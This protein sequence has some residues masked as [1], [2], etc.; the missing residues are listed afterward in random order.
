[1]VH[2]VAG[3]RHDAAAARAAEAVAALLRPGAAR[4]AGR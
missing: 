4:P 1:V 2:V 3:A